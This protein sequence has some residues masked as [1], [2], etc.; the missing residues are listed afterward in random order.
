MQ[1]A[2]T[3]IIHDNKKTWCHRCT[4]TLRKLIF[5]GSVLT[6][7]FNK[8]KLHAVG[9]KWNKKKRKGKRRTEINFCLYMS[10]MN[11]F[12][13]VISTEYDTRSSALHHCILRNT[14]FWMETGMTKFGAVSILYPTLD[15]FRS[16][17]IDDFNEPFKTFRWISTIFFQFFPEFSV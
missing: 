17:P 10:M 5:L 15:L 4:H 8:L 12:L 11:F 16:F 9:R 7:L 14:R 2:I 6:V 13:N 1:I 3:W